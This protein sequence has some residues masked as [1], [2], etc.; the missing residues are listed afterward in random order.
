MNIDFFAYS[1]LIRMLLDLCDSNT[2][3]G[4]NV[5][6]FCDFIKGNQTYNFWNFLKSDTNK[7]EYITLYNRL[8]YVIIANEKNFT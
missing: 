3:T 6:L 8:S 5:E 7:F 1:N 2:L 4:G